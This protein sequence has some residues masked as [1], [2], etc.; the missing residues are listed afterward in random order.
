[1]ARHQLG[2]VFCPITDREIVYMNR[3]L[4]HHSFSSFLRLRNRTEATTGAPIR[5]VTELTG[6]APSKPGIRA[7]RLQTSANAAPA[8]R[9]AGIRPYGRMFEKWPGTGAGRQAK[10]DDRSTI[11]RHDRRQHSCRGDH[12]K[13][14]PLDVQSQVTGIAVAK[15]HQVQRLDQQ[16]R[17]RDQNRHDRNKQHHLVAGNT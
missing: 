17:Q 15:Q 5:A 11:G 2:I 14:C 1:M 6:K 9:T 8:N 12:Q 3:I 7:T 4:S 13:T 16:E 10:K